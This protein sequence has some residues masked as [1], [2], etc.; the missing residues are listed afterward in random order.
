[1]EDS[2]RVDVDDI[3]SVV[4]CESD[5]SILLVCFIRLGG[6]IGGGGGGGGI[7]GDIACVLLVEE[8]LE[9]KL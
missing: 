3:L 1:V 9:F 6:G 4:L 7:G 5:L 2:G 8:L